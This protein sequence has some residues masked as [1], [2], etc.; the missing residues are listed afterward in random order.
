MTCPSV[1]VSHRQTICAYDESF[2]ASAFREA[3]SMYRKRGMFLRSGLKVSSGV[4]VI[5][6]ASSSLMSS[7]MCSAIAGDDVKPG[8]FIPAALMNPLGLAKTEI[9][10]SPDSVFART[11]ANVVMFMFT[12]N[13]GTSLLA[14]LRTSARPSAVVERSSGSS[15]SVAVGPDIRLPSAVR[16]TVMPFPAFDGHE[17]RKLVMSPPVVLSRR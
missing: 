15:C 12:G 7:A 3:M 17:N 9:S 13:D 11:P 6:S 16:R 2:S 5:L 4:R 14:P 8:D 1:T 10:K